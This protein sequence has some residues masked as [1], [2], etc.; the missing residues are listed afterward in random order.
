[1]LEVQP[2]QVMLAG[3][4]AFLLASLAMLGGGV[5]LIAW[6]MR[7]RSENLSKRVDKA[8]WG[9]AAAD[10]GKEKKAQAKERMLTDESPGMTSGEYRQIIRFFARLGVAP[11]K[12]RAW[13]STV[14]IVTTLLFAAGSTPLAMKVAAKQPAA[15]L[16][17]A[18]VG[19]VIGWLL[20]MIVV[21]KGVARHARAIGAALPDALELLAVCV[22]AG[23]SLENALQRVSR[24]MK[25]SQPALSEELATTWAEINILPNR[26]QALVNLAERVNLPAVR[27]VVTTLLQTLRYGTPL[28]KSL[29]V[30]AADV[31]ND[32]LT[33]MEEK[34]NRLPAMMTV[35]VMLFI[36]PTIFLIVGGPAALK[37]MD[38]FFKK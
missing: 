22:E 37:L 5:I 12:A 23:L 17:V 8:R 30:V 34:A 19:A 10:S 27:S 1:M 4:L 33:A 36:M 3:G 32:Q 28:A 16:L 21:R 31:R 20:P 26:D 29:R 24:E 38:I 35:P 7:A 13:F 25:R 6:G 11:E 9:A 18:A 2:D 14:R 15:A